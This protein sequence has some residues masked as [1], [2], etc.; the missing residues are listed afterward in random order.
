MFKPL[1]EEN[2]VQ[3]PSYNFE[4]GSETVELSTET[5]L[6]KIQPTVLQKKEFEYELK[7][8]EIANF[9]TFKLWCYRRM[10]HISEYVY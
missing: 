4:Q 8:P 9:T 1:S 7:Q 3:R 2:K 6:E 10:E 5:L